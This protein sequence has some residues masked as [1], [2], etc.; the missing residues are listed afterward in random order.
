MNLRKK[1]ALYSI[2]RV[3]LLVLPLL[4][5][6]SVLI[7]PNKMGLAGVIAPTIPFFLGYS[8]LIFIYWLYKKKWKRVGVWF[9]ILL[10]GFPFIQS[11]FQ[12]PFKAEALSKNGISV[13]GYNARVFNVYKA[14]RK[15]ENRKNRYQ[16]SKEMLQWIS[17]D[18]SDIKCIQEYYNYN[19]SSIFNSTQLISKNKEYHHFIVP[20]FIDW[21]GAEFGL[22]I[23]SKYPIVSQGILEIASNSNNGGIYAD[24]VKDRDT[25]RIVN[26]H[27]ESMHIH[28]NMLANIDSMFFYSDAIRNSIRVG[29]ESRA[30]QVNQIHDFLVAS[31]YPFILVGDLNE[32]PY[33]YAYRKL[34][35]I[36]KNS[37]QEKGSGFGFTYNGTPFFLRI[38]NQFFSEG[39]SIEFFETLKDIIY[40]DH[41][42]TS[43]VYHLQ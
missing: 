7:S 39:I 21:V 17:D 16:T 24:V 35:S 19:R 12:L 26:I 4:S 11:T 31:P 37:F 40:T 32:L 33:S 15:G 20:K 10:A 5:F 8:F 41:F 1:G 38:D 13:L 18:S 14:L 29:T 34:L 3:V 6:V 25:L 42:P 23:F 30:K 28:Q 43:A 2:I 9:L 22:A 36:S 27:L